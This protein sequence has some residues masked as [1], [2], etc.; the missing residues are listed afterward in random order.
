MTDPRAPGRRVRKLVNSAV[1]LALAAFVT[2]V[3]PAS[4]ATNI[5]KNIG[6]EL[7]SFARPVLLVLA[8]IFMLPLLKQGKHGALL[9]V[10]G[11]AFVIGAFVFAPHSIENMIT[12]TAE[13]VSKAVR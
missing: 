13:S 10:A 5:G 9:A 12:A 4:A 1:L 2:V 11:A 8:A 7:E 3:A 6:N